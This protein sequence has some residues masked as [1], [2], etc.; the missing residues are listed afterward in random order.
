MSSEGQYSLPEAEAL[1]KTSFKDCFEYQQ[2]L[3]KK[4]GELAK[5]HKCFNQDPKISP[6]SSLESV[7]SLLV[8]N[9]VLSSIV[10]SRIEAKAREVQKSKEKAEISRQRLLPLGFIKKL[11]NLKNRLLNEESL[12]ITNRAMQLGVD[13][14]SDLNAELEKELA[15]RK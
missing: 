13:S 6:Y 15:S 1:S 4:I 3:L 7:V 2:R 8:C 14:N 9:K 10:E 12:E 5:N 11:V